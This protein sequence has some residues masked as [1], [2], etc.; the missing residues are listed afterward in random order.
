M[1]ATLALSMKQ[2]R[3]S[4]DELE[5]DED[6][7]CKNVIEIISNLAIIDKNMREM[8]LA[9]ESM[10]DEET[11]EYDGDNLDCHGRTVQGPSLG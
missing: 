1:V 4:Y 3:D 11:M 7:D 9:L 8:K 2:T 5:D 6:E 10:N